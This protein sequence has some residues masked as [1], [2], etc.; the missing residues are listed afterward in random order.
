MTIGI[1]KS[2]VETALKILIYEKINFK[3]IGILEEI[4]NNKTSHEY[5]I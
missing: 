2:K 4:K 3:F 1:L 5:L